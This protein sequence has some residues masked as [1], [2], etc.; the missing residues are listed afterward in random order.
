METIVDRRA[1]VEV[2]H[3]SRHEEPLIHIPYEKGSMKENIA[4]LF[5]S[6][7][8]VS[9]SKAPSKYYDWWSTDRTWWCGCAQ[10]WLLLPLFFKLNT[11]NSRIYNSR[12]LL[13][14]PY[15]C[16]NSDLTEE[17]MGNYVIVNDK[18]GDGKLK[19]KKK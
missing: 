12:R 16:K 18:G 3:A 1:Y 19:K 13:L 6:I 15:D 9:Q 2:Y 11:R 17:E 10:L 14:Y 7:D 4:S 8:W 5:Q